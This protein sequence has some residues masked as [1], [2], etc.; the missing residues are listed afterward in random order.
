MAV[1]LIDVAPTVLDLVG[2]PV[3]ERHQG[4]SLLDP[5]PRMAFFFADYSQGLLG[6]RDGPRKFIYELDTN[7]SRLFDLNRDP[8]EICDLSTGDPART[9]WYAQ[10]LRAW[11][12]AQRALLRA[13]R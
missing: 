7:R 4:R 10:N 11:S 6:L 12:A 5:T 8:G 9:S 3:V 1:S 2:A 13:A